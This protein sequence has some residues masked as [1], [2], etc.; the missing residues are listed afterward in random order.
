MVA[1]DGS[2]PVVEMKNLSHWRLA[3]SV[4]YYRHRCHSSLCPVCNKFGRAE[5]GVDCLDWLD[6]LHAEARSA[7]F[8]VQQLRDFYQPFSPP[9]GLCTAAAVTRAQAEDV[10]SFWPCLDC[11]MQRTLLIHHTPPASNSHGSR[12]RSHGGVMAGVWLM[13]F[14][15]YESWPLIGRMRGPVH[16]DPGVVC[17]FSLSHPWLY[18]QRSLSLYLP[19]SLSP[20]LLLFSSIT[21]SLSIFPTP[22][23]PLLALCL[24]LFTSAI[25]HA[26]TASPLCDSHPDRRWGCQSQP[27]RWHWCL[28]TASTI[29]ETE[30]E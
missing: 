5:V 24:S 7:G 23:L 30:L 25:D 16:L 27:F 29:G 10:K 17:C 13:S 2:L 15:V 6:W 12:G 3:S 28:H 19:L 9:G 11:V 4:V 22:L 18:I 14:A 1:V 21:Y 26:N 20:S 8:L